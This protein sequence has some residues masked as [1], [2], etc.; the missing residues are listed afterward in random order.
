MAGNINV[1]PV[2]P[3]APVTPDVSNFNTM[4]NQS[5]AS[6]F[7]VAAE[8]Q[9]TDTLLT[10]GL[11]TTASTSTTTSQGDSTALN[12]SVLTNLS[13][14]ALVALNAAENLTATGAANTN[15]TPAQLQEMQILQNDIAQIEAAENITPSVTVTENGTPVNLSVAAVTA[16]NEATTVNDITSTSELTVAQIQQAAAVIAPFINQP[17]TPQVVTQIQNALVTAGFS[18]EQLSLQNLFLSMNYVA[19]EATEAY[20]PDTV[21]MNEMVTE[22]ETMEA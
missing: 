1:S 18:P 17:L 14:Q 19:A 22:M 8:V 9:A 20:S 4:V 10:A 3:V 5:A 7:A 16:L 6:S 13:P 15:L 11:N 21:A 12:D 2:P